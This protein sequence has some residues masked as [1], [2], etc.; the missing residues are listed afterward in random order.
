VVPLEIKTNAK[1][2]DSS[3]S[4]DIL[5]HDSQGNYIGQLYFGF[6]KKDFKLYGSCDELV[7]NSLDK[8]PPPAVV[9][10]PTIIKIT[11]TKTGMGVKTR[12]IMFYNGA[13]VLNFDIR[14]SSCDKPIYYR[15]VEKIEFYKYDMS[16]KYYK[17]SP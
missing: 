5:F 13:E 9:G 12:L 3:A 10:D 2:G 16:S 17:I 14:T 15:N 1:M 8:A 7:T 6:S 11:K 4:V